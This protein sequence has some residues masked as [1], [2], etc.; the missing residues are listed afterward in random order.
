MRRPEFISQ[1][2]R[3][4]QRLMGIGSVAHVWVD[5]LPE[6]TGVQSE[7]GKLSFANASQVKRPVLW[8]S[9]QKIFRA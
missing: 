2:C 1:L 4:L 5:E 6:V 9:D 8:P 7:C 3:A